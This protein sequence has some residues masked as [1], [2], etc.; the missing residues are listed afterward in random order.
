MFGL[1]LVPQ[2]MPIGQVINEL[3][4]I[5]ICSEENEFENRPPLYLPYF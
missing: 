1:I 5:I 3:E 2:N 4:I